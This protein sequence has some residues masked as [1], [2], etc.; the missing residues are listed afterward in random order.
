LSITFG[1]PKVFHDDDID[2]E[3]PSGADDEDL[4]A[5]YQTPQPEAHHYSI[6]LAPVAY[7]K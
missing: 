4:I 2:Q 7:Y 5:G 6:M 3:L 1:R